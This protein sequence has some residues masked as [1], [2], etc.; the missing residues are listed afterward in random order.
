MADYQL[1]PQQRELAIVPSFRRVR[2]LAGKNIVLLGSFDSLYV[3]NVWEILTA[4]GAS[5]AHHVTAASDIVIVG[6][7]DASVCDGAD[8][9]LA[10][11][12][13]SAGR[14]IYI[15]KEDVFCRSV[16]DKGWLKL[17]G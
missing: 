4:L 2:P 5:V 11:S 13:K 14:N 16:L 17:L 9:Q 10:I 3:K 15:L 1:P 6:T 12:M 7:A 8:L